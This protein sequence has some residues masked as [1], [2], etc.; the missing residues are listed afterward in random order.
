MGH[1]IPV[2]FCSMEQGK[3]PPDSMSWSDVMEIIVAE[4]ENGNLYYS[5]ASR[6]WWHIN[7]LESIARYLGVWDAIRP[8]FYKVTCLCGD[9]LQSTN[10][11]LKRFMAEIPEYL[12]H[13][14]DE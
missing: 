1:E 7:S 14:I 9:E 13:N 2:F 10:E 8:I 5:S 4:Q 11:G 12:P 3:C 6:G